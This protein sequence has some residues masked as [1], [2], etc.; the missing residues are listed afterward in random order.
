MKTKI[1]KIYSIFL[2]IAIILVV[3]L[4]IIDVNNIDNSFHH[5]IL[6]LFKQKDILYFDVPFIQ[7]VLSIFEIVGLFSAVFA[8]FYILWEEEDVSKKNIRLSHHPFIQ[9]SSIIKFE[10]HYHNPSIYIKNIGEGPSLFTRISFVNNN[11]DNPENAT[12]TSDEP[13]SFYLGKGDI[14]EGIYF[15]DR[16]FYNFI[17]NDKTAGSLQTDYNNRQK[18]NDLVTLIKNK[19][20]KNFY[21]YIHCTDILGEPIIFKVKYLLLIDYEDKINTKIAFMLKRME[22]QEIKGNISL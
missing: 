12:L 22:V 2:L 17:T 13:H 7:T 8:S 10:P 9:S 19:H 20:Q 4:G 16:L 6:H 11:P 18:Y 1:I 14:A 21:I 3:L 5:F 15:D